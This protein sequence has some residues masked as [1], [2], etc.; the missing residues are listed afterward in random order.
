MT[1]RT[2]PRKNVFQAFLLCFVLVLLDAKVVLANSATKDFLFT[3]PVVQ[4]GREGQ[5]KFEYNLNSKGSLAL[6][7]AYLSKGEDLNQTELEESPNASLE[8]QG[9]SSQ[10]LWSRYTQPSRMAGFFWGLGAGYRQVSASWQK[11]PHLEAPE[12][13]Q[14]IGEDGTLTHEVLAKGY[15][16]EA[17]MGYR[18]VGQEWGVVLGGFLGLRHFENQV[19]NKNSDPELF[20]D[21]HTEDENSLR[22][23]MMSALYPSLELGW[24]F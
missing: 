10:L 9:W 22:H 2:K 3:L 6:E 24:A 20:P 4:L 19:K 5:A 11:N 17:R 12:Q 18:Y 21:L 14:L 1:F 13:L 16:V 23:R 15:T 8:S 7:F